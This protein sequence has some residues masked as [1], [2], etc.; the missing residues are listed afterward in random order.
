MFARLFI[1]VLHSAF[2]SAFLDPIFS[3][4]WH[5]DA[6]VLAIGAVAVL[7]FLVSFAL[8]QFAVDR[9]RECDEQ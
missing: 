6:L 1:S 2:W 7:I 5:G 4:H 9:L 8:F 3:R